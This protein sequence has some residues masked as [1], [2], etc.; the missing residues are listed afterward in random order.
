M[1]CACWRREAE[2]LRAR[3]AELGSDTAA[4]CGPYPCG[5]QRRRASAGAR[6]YLQKP[7]AGRLGVKVQ[8][9]ARPTPLFN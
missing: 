1:T 6:I 7:V 4:R 9:L 8:P 2:N 3:S 5:K